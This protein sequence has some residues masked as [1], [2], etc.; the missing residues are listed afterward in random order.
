MK[1][2]ALVIHTP[3]TH[4][5]VFLDERFGEQAREEMNMRYAVCNEFFGSMDFAK[6]AALTAKHGFQGMELAPFTVFGDFSS[7][8][9]AAGLKVVKKGLA[10]SGLE[11]AGLHWLFLKPEGLHV[12]ARDAALRRRSWDHLLRLLDISGELGGGKLIFGSPKQRNSGGIPKDEALRYFAEGLAASADH[13]VACR[14]QILVESLPSADTDII[15]TLAETEELLSRIRHP[16]IS[17]MF[18]FHNATDETDSW[19]MLIDRHWDVVKHIHVN[20]MDG[21]WP[22]TG[23]SDF[24]PAFS[25]LWK[26]GF[27][28]WV[29]LEIFSIP[30]DPERVLAETMAFLRGVEPKT[31]MP[32][33]NA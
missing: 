15:N 17:G 7:Q 14:S 16:G 4:G 11:F 27:P 33:N 29:S 2:I 12:T 21:S 3:D 30:E 22:G 28:H 1:K 24:A 20:E 31:H 19:E 18:D 26:R 5:G 9:I 10:D 32:P 25:L 6:A 8:A 23:T 13:A